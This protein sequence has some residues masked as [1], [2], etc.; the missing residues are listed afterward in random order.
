M[1]SSDS[2]DQL[3]IRK[4]MLDRRALHR[5]AQWNFALILGFGIASATCLM[6]AY[7]VGRQ[8]RYPAAFG[9]FI[10]SLVALVLMTRLKLRRKSILE[11]FS[12][13]TLPEPESPPDFTTLGDGSQFARALEQMNRPASADARDFTN[14]SSEAASEDHREIDRDKDR[15]ANR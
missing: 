14:Q 9:L 6:G 7:D 1:D 15:S 10:A 2:L 5:S 8:S 4:V 11:R 12:K 3:R 13:T